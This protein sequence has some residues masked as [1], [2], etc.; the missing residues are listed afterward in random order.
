MNKTQAIGVIELAARLIQ[1]GQY[2]LS[3]IALN[4]AAM[5]LR[6]SLDDR[7]ELLEA[8]R[9]H[10]GPF[11]ERPHWWNQDKPE[12][13]AQRVA[14]LKSFRQSLLPQPTKPCRSPY[15]ECPIDK[16]SHPGFH[17]ARGT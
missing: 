16:C 2:N 5:R 9:T 11:F 8:Y 1:A 14:A 17:D 10:M 12:F 13:A 15:C 6:W 7:Y 4:E 3:C